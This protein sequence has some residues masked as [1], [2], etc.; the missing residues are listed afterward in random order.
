MLIRRQFRGRWKREQKS[1]TDSANKLEG[2]GRRGVCGQRGECDVT[3]VIDDEMCVN[4]AA[5]GTRW[6][7]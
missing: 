5:P 4:V 2:G 6:V 3:V 7:A 1:G